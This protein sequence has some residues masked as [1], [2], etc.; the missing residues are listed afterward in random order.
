M[1]KGKGIGEHPVDHRLQLRLEALQ[2]PLGATNPDTRKS[3]V[4]WSDARSRMQKAEVHQHG[5][6]ALTWLTNGDRVCDLGKQ[7]EKT[8]R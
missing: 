8:R 6:P 4:F 5:L 2:R 1:P 3:S 7:L